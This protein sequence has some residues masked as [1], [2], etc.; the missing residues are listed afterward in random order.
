MKKTLLWIT[1]VFFALL[2]L[3][4]SASVISTTLITA[5]F[6]AA[7]VALLGILAALIG[8]SAGVFGVVMVYRFLKH[9]TEAVEV[10]SNDDGIVN[11]DAVDIHEIDGDAIA[12]DATEID[13]ESSS[14]YTCEHCGQTWGDQELVDEG[15]RVEGGWFWGCPGCHEWNEGDDPDPNLEE[16]YD[17]DV[18]ADS[19]VLTAD[20]AELAIAL[21]DGAFEL[22]DEDGWADT[23]S[24]FDEGVEVDLHI[25]EPGSMPGS[26]WK[27]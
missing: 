2:A 17:H 5:G 1:S 26:E 27:E 11:L 16:N 23:V 14:W 15:T 25:N 7:K 22:V 4:A 3:P 21:E 20:G 10:E 13:S 24:D 6:L 18:H 8:L 19:E 12:V 9:K